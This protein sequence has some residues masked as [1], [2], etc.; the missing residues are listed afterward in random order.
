MRGHRA[1]LTAG[2]VALLL[3]LSCH[4]SPEPSFVIS[5]TVSGAV[6]SGV[7]VRLQVDDWG[8]ETTTMTTM[9]DSSGAY[10]FEL[11]SSGTYVLSAFR[12]GYTLAPRTQE[13]TVDGADVPGKDFA[14]SSVEDSLTVFWGVPSGLGDL[15]GTGTS[16]RFDAPRSVARDPTTGDFYVADTNN[17]AIRRV[18]PEGMVTTVAG[19]S[20]AWGW[21]DGPGSEARFDS[22]MGVAVDGAGVVYV[23]D[24]NNRTIRMI[25]EG[26]V[27]GTL[28]VLPAG[29]VDVA[30]DGASNVLVSD[31]SNVIWRITPEGHVAA[32][33]GLAGE[34]GCIDGFGTA[35]AFGRLQGLALD[36]TGNLYVADAWCSTV[37]KVTPAGEVTTVAGAPDVHVWR[38]GPVADP[39]PSERAYFEGPRGLALD[40]FTG[41]LY[42]SDVIDTNVPGVLG[43]IRKITPDGYVTTIVVSEFSFG[44]RVDALLDPSGLTLDDAGDLVV[45]DT[46]N[47]ALRRVTPEGV[48]TVLAGVPRALAFADGGIGGPWK[49]RG[50]AVDAAGNVY[51]GDSDA[52]RIY[53][54]SP[55]GAFTSLAGSALPW[56]VDGTGDDAGFEFIEGLAVDGAGNV[57]VADEAVRKVTPDRVVT[58]LEGTIGTMWPE[59]LAVDPDGN[60]FVADCY[61]HKLW[62]IAP[63]GLV[64]TFAGSGLVGNDDGPGE[65]ATFFFPKAIALDGAG[66]LFVAD[67]GNS[68]IRKI[69]PDGMVSTVAGTAG[70]HAFSDGVGPAA[71]FQNP[72]GIATDG[73]GNVY[74]ADTYNHAIR[75]ID[76]DGAVTTVVGAPGRKGNVPGPLPGGL[77]YPKAIVLDPITGNLLIV[78]QDAV[79]VAGL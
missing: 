36:A 53:K 39:N 62:K 7:V 20:G 34:R 44:G 37:R 42:V 76:A 31:Q 10:R 48:V 64:T 29:P 3:A 59:D 11:R 78:V 45:A 1:S 18:T 74:V 35:A 27:V 75:K 26:D 72:W 61:A 73:L 46:G 25:T 24:T 8:P 70:V 66:N 79:M 55:E 14:S 58:T 32:L 68:T 69:T 33:A 13:V 38:D 52:G 51:V 19:L 54:I 63:N 22:P 43:K 71:R 65:S 2:H 57:F 23:A 50:L 47:H 56:R 15:D 9:T 16:A 40:P 49:P 6:S 28:A 17:H 67:A 12:P 5:G 21:E 41:E 30:V 60:A 77:A 4:D